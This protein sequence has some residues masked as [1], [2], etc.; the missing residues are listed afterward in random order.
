[1]ILINGEGE[2]HRFE[3]LLRMMTFLVKIPLT[4]G[5]MSDLLNH[6]V[7]VRDHEGCL[8][9]MSRKRLGYVVELMFKLAWGY[10]GEEQVEFEVVTITK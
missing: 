6:V 4:R 10:V 7:E 8:T 1:M 5:E 3:R 2:T 9:V